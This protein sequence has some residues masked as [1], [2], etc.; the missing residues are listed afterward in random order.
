MTIK[1]F[2]FHDNVA[3]QRETGIFKPSQGDIS[4]PPEGPGHTGN[5]FSVLS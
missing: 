5:M 2:R 3:H 1:S 4:S